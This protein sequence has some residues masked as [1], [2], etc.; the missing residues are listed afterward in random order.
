M[1]VLSSAS[2]SSIGILSTSSELE[3][4]YIFIQTAAQEV[5]TPNLQVFLL[6]I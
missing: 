2:F 1:F 4:Q 5:F 6:I 3:C